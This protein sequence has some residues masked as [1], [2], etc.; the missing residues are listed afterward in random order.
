MDISKLQTKSDP[1]E[2]ELIMPD[3]SETGITLY[4]ISTD[5]PDYKALERKMVVENLSKFTDKSGNVNINLKKIDMDKAKQDRI[6]RLA[7]CIKDWKGIT[8]KGEDGKKRDVKCTYE[9]AV[10]FLSHDHID[11]I[12]E[13]IE[14][15]VSAR[16]NFTKT[17]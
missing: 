17:S 2:F 16:E 10:E 12:I 15:F 13:S 8:E 7:I 1:V 5:H 9:K 4:L 11:W 3:G 14:E 6:K